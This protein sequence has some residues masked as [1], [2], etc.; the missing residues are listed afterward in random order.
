MASAI[1]FRSPNRFGMRAIL[2]V[3]ILSVENGPSHLYNASVL[4][5]NGMERVYRQHYR[6]TPL[7]PLK[8]GSLG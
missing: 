1:Y 5:G 4:A 8:I 2:G 7:Q 6:M 3:P